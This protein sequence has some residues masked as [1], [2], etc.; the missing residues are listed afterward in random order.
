[1]IENIVI[2]VLTLGVVAAGLYL[3]VELVSI[4]FIILFEDFYRNELYPYDNG[5]SYRSKLRLFLGNLFSKFSF[6]S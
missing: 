4:L 3:L 5:S 1:M 6:R 2:I